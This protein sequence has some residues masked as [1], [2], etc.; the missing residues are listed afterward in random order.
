MLGT[1]SIDKLYRDDKGTFY[2]SS[3]EKDIKG[4]TRGDDKIAR[5]GTE[6]K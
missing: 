5:F 6:R 4:L 3:K 2:L 1:G